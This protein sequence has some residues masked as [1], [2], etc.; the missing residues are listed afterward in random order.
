MTT[1]RSRL[2]SSNNY[3][4][5][6]FIYPGCLTKY[7]NFK[8]EVE[9]RIDALSRKKVRNYYDEHSKIKS[10]IIKK[11]EDLNSC[12]GDNLL[13]IKLIEDPDIT[14]FLKTCPSKS[15]CP[16]NR[17]SQV[18]KADVPKHATE[19]PR[20]K[21]SKSYN[22]ELPGNKV[23]PNQNQGKRDAEVSITKNSKVQV[24]VDP[25]RNHAEADG[26]K[27]EDATQTQPWI[28]PFSK[29]VDRE[30]EVSKA[31]DYQ[32]S[33]PL[34]HV[35]LPKDPISDLTHSATTQLYGQLIN[36]PSQR[37]P[38][39]EHV[40]ID[41]SQE[42]TSGKNP[43]QKSP[44][45][46]NTSDEQDSSASPLGTK[47]SRGDYS[48]TET[49]DSIVLSNTIS[50]DSNSFNQVTNDVTLPNVYIGKRCPNGTS[51]GD[52]RAVDAPVSGQ[53]AG[54]A[55]THIEDADNQ[56][57]K[58]STTCG[59][60]SCIEIRNDELIAH[61]SE[62]KGIFDHISNVILNNQ[63][64]MI[65]ASI[66]MG[67]VLLLSLLFKYTPLWTILTKRKRKKQSHMNEKLQRV[68]QKPSIVSEERS[69]PFS[70]SAF[71]YSS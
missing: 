57:S 63:E 48:A 45:S 36:S 55:V 26:L 2:F 68:L 47:D 3:Y 70:Y 24:P 27:Q 65:K 7:S 51:D 12:Y 61:S 13:R 58:S 11:N 22:K 39:Q 1:Q 38:E 40:S 62:K 37:S 25:E 56:A 17:V 69:I 4:A 59:E 53:A 19:D 43:D 30:G 34:G 44:L 23:E 15:N 29:S 8:K 66:P 21:G 67:I 18:K 9:Q 52:K 64:H 6:R 49:S 16:I 32:N 46:A 10:Y 35:E 54:L 60:S 71:E 33:S 50:G 42:I 41:N 5:Q 14:S 28:K 31:T 20:K